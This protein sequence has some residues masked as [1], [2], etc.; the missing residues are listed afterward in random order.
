MSEGAGMGAREGL[1]RPAFR[2]WYPRL[3]PGIWCK[4]SWLAAAVLE[5]QQSQGPHWELSERILS[6]A[7][8]LFR[9]GPPSPASRQTRRFDPRTQRSPLRSPPPS[10]RSPEHGQGRG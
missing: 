10:T 5:Q 4:A 6:D 2:E 1:L 7:H 3:V 9:G 8:F